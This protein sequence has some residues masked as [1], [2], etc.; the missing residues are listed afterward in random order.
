[1]STIYLSLGSNLGDK[2]QNLENAIQEI[3]QTVG[4]LLAQSSIYKSEAVGFEGNHFNNLVIKVQTKLSPEKLLKETQKIEIKMGRTEKT[5][6]K[7]G[8]PVYKNR[9]IDIDILLYDDIQIN[10]ETLKI[11][12]P[13]MFEREFVMIPLKE[14]SFGTINKN[15]MRATTLIPT[16]PYTQSAKSNSE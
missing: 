3:Q 4:E 12:H 14:V 1:M 15:I 7:N 13:R 2:I 8:I 6:I 16:Q 10:T 9:I 5:V 11:P